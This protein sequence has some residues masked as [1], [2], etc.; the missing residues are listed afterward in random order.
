LKTWLDYKYRIRRVLK[1]EK[2]KDDDNNKK[3]LTEYRTP[4][5]REN[6][7]IFAVHKDNKSNSQV[8]YFDLVKSFGKTLD[9]IGKG[10]REVGNE[11]RRQITFHSFRRFVKNYYI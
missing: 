2:Q 4:I 1:K 10:T 8:M 5:R 6:D 3:T 9:R 11:R 7:L